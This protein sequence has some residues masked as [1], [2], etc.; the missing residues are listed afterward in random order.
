VRQDPM[1]I[2]WLDETA[3]KIRTSRSNEILLIIVEAYSLNIN[4]SSKNL[5]L[6]KY[7]I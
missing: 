5:C 2:K 6:K 7:H 3:N 1:H 4:K